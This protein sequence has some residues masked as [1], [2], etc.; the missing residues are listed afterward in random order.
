MKYII[1][2]KKILGMIQ[3]IPIIFP[4]QL[5]HLD[6]A[7]ALTKVIG[8]SR[9]VG[10]GDCYIK[11]SGVGGKSTT[12]GIKSKKGDEELINTFEYFYGMQDKES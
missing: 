3:K 10:A 6:V 7:K 12:I 2:E 5:V 4:N 8:S 1:Y 9:I 11:V